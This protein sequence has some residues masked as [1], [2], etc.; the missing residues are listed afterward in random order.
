MTTIDRRTLLAGIGAGTALTILGTA[1]AHARQIR[2]IGLQLYTVREIFAKDPVGTLEQIARIGYR[3]VE[4][5]G[6]DY[7]KMDHAMLRRTLDRLKLRAP[8]VHV[9]YAMLADRFDA[10][11][12]MARTLGAETIVMPWLPEEQRTEAAFEQVIGSLDGIATRLKAQ[13]LA[14]AYHNHDFEFTGRSRGVSLFD[15]LLTVTDPALVRFELDLYWAAHAGEDIPQLV[16]RLSPRLW[17]FHVKDMAPDRSMT[18]VGAGTIDF[19]A[20]F[21]LPG[22]AGVRHYFVENDEAPAPYLPDI[23]KSYQTLRA[24]RF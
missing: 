4:F 23:T 17:S 1:P 3:E 16:K 10:A 21:R 15:R 18:S 2:A 14:F 20:I 8:S 22:A 11:V 24:L 13:G 9:P 7:D 12:K 6:G 19:A 5:G